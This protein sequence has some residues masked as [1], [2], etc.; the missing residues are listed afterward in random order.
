MRPLWAGRLAARHQSPRRQVPGFKADGGHRPG[1]GGRVRRMQLVAGYDHGVA[2][3]LAES[4]TLDFKEGIH[5]QF[6]SEHG[7]AIEMRAEMRGNMTYHV[8]LLFRP[9]QTGVFGTETPEYFVR[10]VHTT[11][12]RGADG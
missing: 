11:V 8:G 1:R 4:S 5:E 9:C 6:L 7:T 2:E 12:I 3:S 10:M